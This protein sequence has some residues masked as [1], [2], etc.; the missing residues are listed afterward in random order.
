M[1]INY[2]G[3][4]CF[5]VSTKGGSL[6]ID[7]NLVSLGL[8]SIA[9]DSD[10]ALYTQAGLVDP[11]TKAKLLID[12]P[13]EYELGDISIVGLQTRA[14][15]KDENDLSATVYKIMTAGLQLAVIGHVFPKLDESLIEALTAVDALVIPVGGGGYTLTAE[16]A[17]SLSKRLEPRIVVPSHFHSAGINYQQ[18]QA[19][20]TEF[21]N[22]I[23]AHPD[24]VKVLK[25]KGIIEPGVVLM[26]T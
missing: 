11:S 22:K 16:E 10:V 9:G 25:L 4:N 26:T 2:Y 21:L 1:D 18:D 13:G 5:K 12:G 20:V 6:V 14:Y 7:D 17:V 3:A 24:P 19:P 23:E 15:G 8:K